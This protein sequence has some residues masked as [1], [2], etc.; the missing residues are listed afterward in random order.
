MIY[1]SPEAVWEQNPV[2][3]AG[4]WEL[5]DVAGQGRLDSMM[6]MKSMEMFGLRKGVYVSLLKDGNRMLTHHIVYTINMCILYSK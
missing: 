1:H 3:L 5:L 6:N 2:D 4:V